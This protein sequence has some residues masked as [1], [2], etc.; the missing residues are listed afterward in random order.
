MEK[1]KVGFKLWQSMVNTDLTPEEFVQ[2]ERLALI[3]EQ[4]VR[5]LVSGLLRNELRAFNDLIKGSDNATKCSKPLDQDLSPKR[6]RGRPRVVAQACVPHIDGIQIEVPLS[7][8][9]IIE[10]TDD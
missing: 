6:K 3:R 4:S 5:K 7:L 10:E 1:R 8:E 9:D 2:L